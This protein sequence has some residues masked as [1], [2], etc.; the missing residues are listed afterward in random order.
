MSNVFSG[1]CTVGRDAEVR[2][3]PSGQAVLNVSVANNVGFGDKQQTVWLRVVLWG[4]R[5][6]GTLK[7]YLKKG[8]QVFVSGELTMSEYT[9][10]DGTKKTNL[11]LNATIIDLVGKR[12]SA[13]TNDYNAPAP[14]QNYAPQNY[15]QPPAQNYA[16][17]PA[18][19]YAPPKPRPAVA[20]SF[21]APYDD[22]IPF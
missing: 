9:A 1:V 4:R 2:Y 17:P 19:S 16:P 3:L 20:P 18:P 21:D 15:Q 7:D 6:E 14:A 10:N 8:Q 22:D 11:E 13:G 12:E 5:A